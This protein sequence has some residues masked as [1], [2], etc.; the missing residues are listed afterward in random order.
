MQHKPS[1]W[2]SPVAMLALCLGLGERRRGA[3]PDGRTART[4]ITGEIFAEKPAPMAAP[5][6]SRGCTERRTIRCAVRRM[7]R[8]P[9]Q[10]STQT[11]LKWY[12]VVAGAGLLWRRA[13][14]H[15]G[16]D[17]CAW[18]EAPE[19][20]VRCPY[21]VQPRPSSERAISPK[22]SDGKSLIVERAPDSAAV[23]EAI[24]SW[25]ANVRTF[26]LQNNVTKGVE[27]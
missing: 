9:V 2:I 27:L 16:F 12:R 1:S 24:E 23:A 10:T 7:A 19:G 11:T 8:R 5:G 20:S 6:P 13:R 21:V 15:R 14:K 25:R 18:D 26:E 3:R 22:T 17:L 4:P